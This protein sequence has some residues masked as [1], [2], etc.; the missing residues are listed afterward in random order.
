MNIR[1]ILRPSCSREPTEHQW[2]Q[3][4]DE[5]EPML[6]SLP[7]GADLRALDRL[8]AVVTWR[9]RFDLEGDA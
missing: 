9:S 2:E 3:L 8:P 6:K 1:S 7:A 4:E 5:L